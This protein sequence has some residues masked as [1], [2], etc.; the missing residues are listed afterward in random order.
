MKVIRPGDRGV[1]LLVNFF[2]IPI[3]SR[4]ICNNFIHIFGEK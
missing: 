2:T 1:I 4:Q 3:F